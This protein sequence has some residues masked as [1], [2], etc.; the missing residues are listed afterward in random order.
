MV[1]VL[2]DVMRPEL[3]STEK[4]PLPLLTEYVT[5]PPLGEMALTCPMNAPGV[6]LVTVNW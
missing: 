3:G 5:V 4:S 1:G 6:Q 2:S